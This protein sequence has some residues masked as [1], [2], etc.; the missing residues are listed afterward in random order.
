M[1]LDENK[2]I[3][4]IYLKNNFFYMG[5]FVEKDDKFIHF[6][7]RKNGK[8]KI[9]NLDEVREMQFLNEGDEE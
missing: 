8:L 7:D 3:V 4:K 1:R 9:F 6:I 2:K 5:K